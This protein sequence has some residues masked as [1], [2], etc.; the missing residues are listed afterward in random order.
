M[1]QIDVF[2]ILYF[3][4]TPRN[5]FLSNRSGIFTNIFK[6]QS[7]PD[8]YNLLLSGWEQGS[9]RKPYG[10]ESCCITKRVLGSCQL[11]DINATLLKTCTSFFPTKRIKPIVLLCSISFTI[12][13]SYCWGTHTRVKTPRTTRRYPTIDRDA[14]VLGVKITL[15]TMRKAAG[16]RPKP[17]SNSMAVKSLLNEVHNIQKY[18]FL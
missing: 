5:N 6:N 9:N 17:R 11:F 1:V 7:L 2:G 10:W 13:A 12:I 3:S 15:P 14:V 4:F 8:I 16:M 18:H